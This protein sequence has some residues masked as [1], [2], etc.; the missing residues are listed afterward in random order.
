VARALKE[1]GP[2]NRDIIILVPSAEEDGLKG[3]E[4]F[5]KAPPVPL[6]QLEGALE[7][8]KKTLRS[9]L[10]RLRTLFESAG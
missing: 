3:T 1:A 9:E 2:T 5:I 10:E 4:A 7:Q 8:Q 6:E